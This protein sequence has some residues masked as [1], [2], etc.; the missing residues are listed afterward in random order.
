MH[1]IQYII[2]T[3]QL[4]KIN[5]AFDITLFICHVLFDMQSIK[6]MFENNFY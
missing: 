3:V 5:F 6:K 1:V 2:H 4:N